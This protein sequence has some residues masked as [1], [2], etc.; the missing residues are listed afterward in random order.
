MAA[1]DLTKYLLCIPLQWQLILALPLSGG[2]F[3]HGLHPTSP[4][5]PRAGKVG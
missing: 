5:L 3:S 1:R 2:E 4:L